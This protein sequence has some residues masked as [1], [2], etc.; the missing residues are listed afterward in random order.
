MA[1]RY[2]VIQ[3]VPNPIA[4]ERINIGVLAFDQQTVKVHFLS[5]WDRVRCFGRTQDMETL[6]NFAERMKKSAEEGRL[7]PG[8]EPNDMPNHERL[9]KVVH[10]WIN[11]IQFT[12]PRAYLD[13]VDSVF[14]DAIETYLIDREPGYQ[15]RN[16][17]AAAQ[18]AKSKVKNT[19]IQKLG[20]DKAKELL[21]TDY[22]ILGEHQHHTW[23]VAVANGQ[24]LFAA[25]AISFEVQTP[26][27]VRDS[28][29]WMISDVKKYSA[30]FPLGIITLPPRQ[31]SSNYHSLKKVYEETTSTYQNLG[32]T[33][34]NENRVE[35]CVLE[36]L[37]KY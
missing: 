34:I 18:L 32:A 2:S 37:E 9:L 24:P 19:L 35:A 33:V 30:N 15:F 11:Q 17:Q 4:N 6:K 36:Q 13:T 21:K 28:L 14:S 31:N 5:N 12:K 20:K 22:Q 10:G 25:H 26:T 16:R 1:S 29:A 8:D 23:D 27:S 3:Y 7:F